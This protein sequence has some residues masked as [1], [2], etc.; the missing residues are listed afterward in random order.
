[1]R[2]NS[3]LYSCF[4]HTKL[5]V[6]SFVFSCL[7]KQR[8]FSNH[9]TDCSTTLLIQ[10]TVSITITRPANVSC[11]FFSPSSSVPTCFQTVLLSLSAARWSFAPC[12]SVGVYV[13]ISLRAADPCVPLLPHF[14][15]HTGIS[16]K[17]TFFV[18][19]APLISSCFVLLLAAPDLA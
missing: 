14:P 15:P 3:E 5:T 9:V 13:S 12:P 11:F 10:T 19:S 7:M 4:P 17:S 16:A 8:F 6:C 18:F 2:D 1:M